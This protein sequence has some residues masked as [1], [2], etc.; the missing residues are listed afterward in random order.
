[1]S[2]KQMPKGEEEIMFRSS[3]ESKAEIRYRKIEQLNNAGTGK[4]Y[5][6]EELVASSLRA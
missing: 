5:K 2:E 6:V 1:M 3:L 4:V